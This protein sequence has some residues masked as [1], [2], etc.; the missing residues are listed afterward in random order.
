VE[1]LSFSPSFSEYPLVGK[2]HTQFVEERGGLAAL[3]ALAALD[4]KQLETKK[5][6]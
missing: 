3:T 4:S 1:P 5:I 2:W 6:A